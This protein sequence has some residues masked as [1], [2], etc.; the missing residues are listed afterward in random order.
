MNK[1]AKVLF[2]TIL[3][4]VGWRALRYFSGRFLAADD[5]EAEQSYD[6]ARKEQ[7]RARGALEE[8]GRG[9]A[10]RQESSIWSEQEEGREEVGGR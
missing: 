6:R 3:A 1:A 9:D 5:L 2:Y 8:R 4:V 7:A 10:L